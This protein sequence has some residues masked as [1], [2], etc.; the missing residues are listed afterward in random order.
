MTERN[1][2]PPPKR[3]CRF[4]VLVSQAFTLL[5]PPPAQ[6]SDRV[7][8]W[9]GQLAKKDSIFSLRI[10]L[11]TIALACEALSRGPAKGTHRSLSQ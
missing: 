2:L 1:H 5:V 11:L 4:Q 10:Y 6:P 7:F 9:Q 3:A 8:T